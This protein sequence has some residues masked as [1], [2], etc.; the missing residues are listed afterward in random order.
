MNK[1]YDLN[2]K[3]GADFK[4]KEN[5]SI[6]N[7][8]NVDFFVFGKT[9]YCKNKMTELPK[10][11]YL[12]IAQFKKYGTFLVVMH[13]VFYILKNYIKYRHFGKAFEAVPFEI[14][15]RAYEKMHS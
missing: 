12:H 3:P 15:A 6:P 5:H 4:I 8:M 13:Y 10:H 2:L 1:K 9:M 11:E 7:K 14:E